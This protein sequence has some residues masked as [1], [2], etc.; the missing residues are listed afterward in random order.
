MSDRDY[1]T[2]LTIEGSDRANKLVF[3][4]DGEVHKDGTVD[5]GCYLAVTVPCK[6]DAEV[7]GWLL[8]CADDPRLTICLGFI[9]DMAER[10][11]EVFNIWS[12]RRVVRARG[13]DPRVMTPQEL[14]RQSTGRHEFG[15][16]PTW[17]VPRAISRRVPASVSTATWSRGC[18]P[19]SPT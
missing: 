10:P 1:I 4:K 9:P 11:G 3:V 2:V 5:S 17:T 15:G 16:V 18:R 12:K 8:H 13:M 6:T 14:E 7:A 19:S